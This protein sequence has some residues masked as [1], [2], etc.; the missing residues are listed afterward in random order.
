MILY[1]LRSSLAD[2]DDAS[3]LCEQTSFFDQRLL[4][5]LTYAY[6]VVRPAIGFTMFLCYT[7]R[8]RS[9]I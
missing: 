5:E 3:I 7:V 2:N 9:W 8:H 1:N 4:D 6:A